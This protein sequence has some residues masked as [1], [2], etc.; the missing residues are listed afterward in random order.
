MK[1]RF[2][3]KSSSGNNISGSKKN[4]AKRIQTVILNDRGQRYIFVSKEY[5]TLNLHYEDDPESPLRGHVVCLK[6]NEDDK[7][8]CPYCAIDENPDTY[9]FIPVLPVKDLEVKAL[10]VKESSKEPS[11]C[12]QLEELLPDLDIDTRALHIKYADREF[13]LKVMDQPPNGYGKNVINGFLRL[14]KADN[15]DRWSPEL[16]AAMQQVY[17]KYSLEELKQ[18]VKWIDDQFG[19]I[20]VDGKGLDD[21]C[22]EL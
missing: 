8:F 20:G 9:L 14:Y 7:T 2:S 16:E 12:C 21:E 6:N 4:G 3:K 13:S 1:N 11:L 15:D 10:R 22:E 5:A 19:S 17:P 18:N